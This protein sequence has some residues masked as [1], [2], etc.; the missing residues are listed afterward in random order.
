MGWNPS[1]LDRPPAWL[2]GDPASYLDPPPDP[3]PSV[4]PEPRPAPVPPAP[5][6]GPPD[7]D[8]PF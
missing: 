4:D 1:I 5:Y 6:E 2:P 7:P 8:L 3:E